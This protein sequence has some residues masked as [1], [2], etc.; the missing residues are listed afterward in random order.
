[1]RKALSRIIPLVQLIGYSASLLVASFLGMFIL[2]LIQDIEPVLR[3]H[4]SF[5]APNALVIS[6]E[7]SM[8]K[9]TEKDGLYFTENDLSEL[10]EQTFVEA[11]IPFEQANFKVSASIGNSEEMPGFRTEMFLEALPS[12]YL[13]FD[14]EEWTWNED[15]GEVPIVLPRYYLTLYN[16]GFAESQGLPVISENMIQQVSFQL[17][18]SGQGLTETF[19][20]RIVGFTDKINSILVHKDFLAMANQRFGSRER[21]LS[22]LLVEVN[23]ERDQELLQFFNEQNYTVSEQDV[24]SSKVQF[25]GKSLM[26]GASVLSLVVLILALGFIFLCIRLSME[27]NRQRIESLLLLGF[28]SWQI[29]LRYALTVGFITAISI[30]LSTWLTYTFRLRVVGWL[31]QFVEVE[32]SRDSMFLWSFFLLIAVLLMNL[33][34]IR[35][36]LRKAARQF[37]NG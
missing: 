7:V 14:M 33:L 15:A 37:V 23:G 26:Y 25:A 29:T 5:F 31:E 11:V 4:T 18:C 35:I 22:R 20:A 32:P 34:F 1:M 12:R 2:A 30:G 17:H 36:P 13:D 9:T 6:K 24:E 8:F 21:N 28:S 16:F 3:S 19:N 27:K 10:Q